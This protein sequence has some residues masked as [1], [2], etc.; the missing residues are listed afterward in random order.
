M[1][2]AFLKKYIIIS[3]KNKREKRL[4]PFLFPIYLPEFTRS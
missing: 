3:I 2:K 1:L 4:L